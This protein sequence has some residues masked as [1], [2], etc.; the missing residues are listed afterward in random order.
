MF[1]DTSA[2]NQAHVFSEKAGVETTGITL[3][4]ENSIQTSCRSGTG[5]IPAA[6]E[7]MVPSSDR[8]RQDL[9]WI[10]EMADEGKDAIEEVKEL[11]EN[12]AI[13]HSMDSNMMTELSCGN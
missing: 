10:F 1:T 13:P 6:S 4:E 12:A 7:H 5:V 2:E 9:T 8:Y 3:L 11:Y